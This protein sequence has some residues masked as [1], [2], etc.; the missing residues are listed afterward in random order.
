MRIDNLIEL[1]KMFPSDMYVY[2]QTCEGDL[3][4]PL[5]NRNIWLADSWID[6]RTGGIEPAK[7]CITSFV[8]GDRVYEE[9]N[10]HSGVLIKYEP[11]PDQGTRDSEH[12]E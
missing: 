1:L 2:V 8:K 7:L 11:A 10:K 3:L 6:K 12:H 9:K 5:G 4:S